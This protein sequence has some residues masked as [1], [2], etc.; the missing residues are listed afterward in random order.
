MQSGNQKLSLYQ[1][2]LLSCVDI[3]PQVMDLTLILNIFSNI[4]TVLLTGNRRQFTLKSHAI[5]IM[6][7]DEV[8]IQDG[9]GHM[10]GQILGGL[11][12]D[13]GLLGSQDPERIHG[14]LTIIIRLFWQIGLASNISKTKTMTCHMRVIRSEMSEE[15]LGRR[16]TGKGATYRECLRRKMPCLD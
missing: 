1:I 12:A 9:L 10:V 4:P 8:V 6:V 14:A 5:G 2:L 16:I 13:D 3:P 15:A 11:Y 7:E